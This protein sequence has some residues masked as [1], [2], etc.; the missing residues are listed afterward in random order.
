MSIEI[1]PTD[2]MIGNYIPIC[3]DSRFEKEK[4]VTWG[5]S[6][7]Y[8]YVHYFYVDNTSQILSLLKKKRES[9]FNEDIEIY[10]RKKSKQ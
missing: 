10:K 4:P 5:Y 3:S 8:C 6:R 1:R 2:L 9:Y 7:S